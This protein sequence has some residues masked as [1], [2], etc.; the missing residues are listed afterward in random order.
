M[1]RTDDPHLDVG[2]Y[3]LHA[4]PADEEAAF[5]NHLAGCTS[6]RLEAEQ[7]SGAAVRLGASETSA[8]PADLRRRVLDRI[9]TVRQDRPGPVASRRRRE[10]RL[11]PALAASLAAAAALG[12]VAWW[13]S[14][15]ADTARE[16][17]ALALAETGRL[18]DVLTAPDATIT[19]SKLEYGGNAAV[20]ASRGQDRSAFIASQLPPL[21][22]DRVY[23]LWYADSG[24][25][26]PAGLLPATGGRQS[27]VLDGRLSGAT[28]VCI[29]VEP[30]GGSPRP[31]T[32]ILAF[33]SLPA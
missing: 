3:V 12:G 6:C 25:Y 32:D 19:T 24:W 9:G 17:S 13:Q 10:R 20:V 26:R 31:T 14:S 7:L 30:A 1:N 29:T 33:I 15:E 8:P 28:A 22:G 5:E 4:L 16:Q 18:A 21:A 23:E 2:A 27:R 11:W